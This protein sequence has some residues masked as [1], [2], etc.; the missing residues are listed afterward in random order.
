MGSRGKGELS[1][2]EYELSSRA[3]AGE[4]RLTDWAAEHADQ[5]G[6]RYASELAR[7]RNRTQAYEKL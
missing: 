4:T 6:R 3:P 2:Q 5:L 7:R 1:I